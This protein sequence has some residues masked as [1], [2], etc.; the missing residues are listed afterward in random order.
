MKTLLD[1]ARLSLCLGK[2]MTLIVLSPLH[3]AHGQDEAPDKLRIEK[4]DGSRI[5]L[6]YLSFD[7]ADG[8]AVFAAENGT[9]LEV[10]AGDIAIESLAEISARIPP[11]AGWLPLDKVYLCVPPIGALDRQHEEEAAQAI[12]AAAKA[13]TSVK[14]RIALLQLHGVVQPLLKTDHQRQDLED[15]SLAT[16]VPRLREWAHGA[17]QGELWYANRHAINPLTGRDQKTPI[18]EVATKDLERRLKNFIRMEQDSKRELMLR[19]AACNLFARYCEISG[20]GAYAKELDELRAKITARK[21]LTRD[22]EAFGLAMLSW[23]TSRV[24]VHHHSGNNA[25][26]LKGIF[27]KMHTEAK[28]DQAIPIIFYDR[29]PGEIFKLKAFLVALTAEEIQQSHIG[30]QILDRRL[31]EGMG[32]IIPD[33]GKRDTA[34]RQIKPFIL[35]AIRMG[36]R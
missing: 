34:I 17:Y 31:R 6:P 13:A 15:P 3:H 8:V 10:P 16:S 23:M 29:P 5:H 4:L 12:F 24:A 33:P 2:A 20:R 19:L 36:S 26:L 32:A 27:A 22:S 18:M 25:A 11:V 9:E 7:V 35:E 28:V 14:E 30:D 1:L 21:P